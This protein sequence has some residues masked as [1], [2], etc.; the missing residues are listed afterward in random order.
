[1][2]EADGVKQSMWQPG[3]ATW[4]PKN[5]AGKRKVYDVLIVGGGI[6]GLTT[7]LLLQE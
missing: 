2:Y 4:Q 6:T 5:E 3:L 1:M 7:V